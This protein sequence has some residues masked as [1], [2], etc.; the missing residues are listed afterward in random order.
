MQLSQP[1]LYVADR[2]PFAQRSRALV[3]LL[4]IPCEQVEIDLDDR[5]PEFLKLTPTG[6]VPL[7]LSK[8]AKVYE[9]AQ[10][11]LYLAERYGFADAW[12]EDVHLRARERLLMTQWDGLV[13]PAFYRTLGGDPLDERT[14]AKLN[15]EL[16]EIVSTIHATG[17]RVGGLASLHCAP[18]WA[19]ME[20]LRTLSPLA[21][22]IA[23]RVLLRTWLDKSAALP[24]IQATLT[25][26]AA[27]VA[28]YQARRS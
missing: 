11:N 21:D 23:E 8:E 28:R 12:H 15:T 17:S 16:A 19:R 5:D 13:V 1:R 9:S 22:L 24:C 4:A 26:Q 7:W 6:T 14:Q 18:F 2:C 10:V 25:D 3:H 27:T 20:W